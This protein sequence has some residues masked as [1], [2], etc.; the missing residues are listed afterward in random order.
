MATFRISALTASVLATSGAAGGFNAEGLV[1]NPANPRERVVGILEKFDCES[2]LDHAPAG[3]WATDDQV[4]K[5]CATR[6][7]ESSTPR[8]SRSIHR[9]LTKPL[10]DLSLHRRG[11]STSSGHLQTTNGLPDGPIY[12]II[13]PFLASLMREIP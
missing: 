6:R 10:C 8:M 12:I 3:N 5:K 7:S 2:L 9:Y 1:G 11:S 4:A 13:L